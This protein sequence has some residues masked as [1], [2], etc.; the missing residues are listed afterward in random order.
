MDYAVQRRWKRKRIS[1]PVIVM[2]KGAGQTRTIVASTRDICDGG[3]YVVSARCPDCGTEVEVRIGTAREV[4]PL[5][6]DGRVVRKDEWGFAV[7]FHHENSWPFL[8]DEH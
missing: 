8:G 4:S 5:D 6:V 2:I 3:V 7:A 1:A